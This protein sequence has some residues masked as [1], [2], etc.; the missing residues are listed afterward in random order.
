MSV[1]DYWISKMQAT[2]AGGEETDPEATVDT[3]AE[4]VEVEDSVNPDVTAESEDEEEEDTYD[5]DKAAA[6]EKVPTQANNKQEIRDYL[7]YEHGIDPE[8]LQGQTKAELLD[9]VRD[10]AE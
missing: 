3:P 4:T 9:L 1:N 2:E 10:L 7:I 8:D 6:T 5:A